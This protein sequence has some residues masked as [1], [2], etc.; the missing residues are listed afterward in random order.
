MVRLVKWAHAVSHGFNIVS[1]MAIIAMVILTCAD[2]ILRLLGR[3][4]VGTYE[5]IGFLGAVVVSFSLAYT[6]IQKGHVSV[7]ILVEKLPERLQ[8]FIDF[9][10]GTI[11]TILFGLLSWQSTIYALDLKRSGEVSMTLQMPVYPFI[12]GVALG[13]TLL[14]LV[15][16]FETIRSVERMV[17]K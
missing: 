9:I 14:C 1:Y 10:G 8:V 7:E 15:L 5:M 16:I 12:L 3:P 2:V 13:S 6:S 17:K 11:S 4:I